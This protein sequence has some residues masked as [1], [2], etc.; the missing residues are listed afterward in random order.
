LPVAHGGRKDWTNIATACVSCNKREGAR[1]PAE[2]GM[3]LKRAP[4]KPHSTPALRGTVGLRR[5][6][7][8]WRDFLYW[9]AELENS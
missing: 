7:D 5:T 3:T 8:S 4:R 9:N 2:A 1:T 6:P